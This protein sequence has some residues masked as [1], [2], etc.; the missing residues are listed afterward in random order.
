MTAFSHQLQQIQPHQRRFISCSRLNANNPHKMPDDLRIWL[1]E[2][3]DDYINRMGDVWEDEKRRNAFTKFL[4][5]YGLEFLTK[6]KLL[7]TK[8]YKK[9][10][11]TTMY[12]IRH[13]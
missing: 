7:P 12:C 6:Q 3:I 9:L 1:L 5:T 11:K 13:G 10:V 2:N 4:T 8:T